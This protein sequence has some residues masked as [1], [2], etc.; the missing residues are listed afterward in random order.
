[1]VGLES[2]CL[3]KLY[4]GCKTCISFVQNYIIVEPISWVVVRIKFKKYMQVASN[5]IIV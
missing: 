2:D 5:F 1:M 4:F 3:T